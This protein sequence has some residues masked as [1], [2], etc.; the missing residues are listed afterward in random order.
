MILIPLSRRLK[1]GIGHRP[2][3]GHTPDTTSFEILSVTANSLPLNPPS[4][5]HPYNIP[6]SAL[7]ASITGPC[8]EQLVDGQNTKCG[9]KNQ[10]TRATETGWDR[11]DERC[12]T[13]ERMS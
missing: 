5:P 13:N 9:T 6:R 10:D 7:Y 8:E 1:W 4:P 12:R 3:H 11:P 2:G